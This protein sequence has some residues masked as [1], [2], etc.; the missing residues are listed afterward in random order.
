MRGLRAQV[1]ASGPRAP[2]LFDLPG[3]A[4]WSP[5]SSLRFQHPE[6]NP[7]EMGGLPSRGPGSARPSGS[8]QRLRTPPFRSR[9]GHLYMQGEVG[10]GGFHGEN[11]FT[12][13]EP[14]RLRCVA[15]EGAVSVRPAPRPWG[16]EGI[17]FHPHNRK[18]TGDAGLGNGRDSLCAQPRTGAS[19]T[20]PVG[21]AVGVGLQEA[22]ART[23]G[24]DGCARC[25]PEP[26]VAGRAALILLWPF[27]VPAHPLCP[28]SAHHL[29]GA[30][31]TLCSRSFCSYEGVRQGTETNLCGQVTR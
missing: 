23:V 19:G 15:R 1:R 21:P 7:R 17:E 16:Q 10:P 9:E 4:K 28:L 6:R 30:E 3:S 8:R 2:Y 18:L 29:P 12:V 31:A 14:R 26:W 27:P 11:V 22:T 24:D 25:P 13:P 20:G 5:G